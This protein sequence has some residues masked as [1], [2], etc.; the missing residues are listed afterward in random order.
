[1]TTQTKNKGCG[2]G[3]GFWLFEEFQLNDGRLAR[4]VVVYNRRFNDMKLEPEWPTRFQF[5]VRDQSVL[6][7]Q[8]EIYDEDG[9]SVPVQNL[10]ELESQVLEAFRDD[11]DEVEIYEREQR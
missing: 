4:F 10:L 1:M 11:L 8:S 9:N 6:W 2:D 7:S 5:Q 3:S